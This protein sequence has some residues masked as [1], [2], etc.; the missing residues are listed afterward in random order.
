MG[1]TRSK[2]LHRSTKR[3]PQYSL[4]YMALSQSSVISVSAVSQ[5]C[6]VRKPDCLG[7]KRLFT[8]RNLYNEL[9]TC[10]SMTLDKRGRIKICL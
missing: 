1:S 3:T 7:D 6:L 2:A 8:R 4:L 9:Y 5:E 10:F